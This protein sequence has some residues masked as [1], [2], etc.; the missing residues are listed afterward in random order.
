MSSP[1][2]LRSSEDLHIRLATIEDVPAIGEI[3]TTADEAFRSI[4]MA[5]IADSECPDQK[6]YIHYTSSRHMWVVTCKDR[7]QST[8]T[9]DFPMAFIQ[10]DAFENDGAFK[11]TFVRQI[12]VLP[13]Y[14]RRGIGGRLIAHV[15]KWAMS[16]GCRAVDLTTF[17][18]VPWNKSYYEKLGYDVLGEK[19]LKERNCKDVRELLLQERADGLLGR[20]E[21]VAMRKILDS[22]AQQWIRNEVC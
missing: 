21:R 14:A 13:S 1:V 22:S 5:A 3:E 4:D 10:V 17:E 16:K 20:W 19:D 12:S 15:E 7:T 8:D 11:T 18:H 9:D 2:L 6:T